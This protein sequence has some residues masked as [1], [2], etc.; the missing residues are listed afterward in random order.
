MASASALRVARFRQRQRDEEILL[1]I[2]VPEL[3]L[4]EALEVA[5][6]LRPGVDHSNDDIAHGVERLIQLFVRERTQ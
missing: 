4:V 1:K 5:E 6:L 2:S 3:P